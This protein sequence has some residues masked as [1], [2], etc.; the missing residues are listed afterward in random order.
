[1]G[2]RNLTGAG[3]GQ[4]GGKAGNVELGVLLSRRQISRAVEIFDG[5]WESHCAQE[6]TRTAL[7]PFLKI[8]RASEERRGG[9]QRIGRPMRLPASRVVA[10]RRLRSDA[11]LWVKAMYHRDPSLGE[12]WMTRTWI[13]DRHLPRADG[14]ISRRPG[15]KLGDRIVL[16]VVDPGRCPAIYVVTGLPEDRRDLVRAVF[17]AEVDLYG[18]VT[19][20][21]VL[22]AVP[23]DRAPGLDV[24]GKS[25]QGLQNGYVRLDDRDAY[26]RLERRLLR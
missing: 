23:L 25:P 18:W 4:P 26:R 19:P 8:E 21:D 24:L 22:A 13:H 7:A 14:G 9:G 20:V 15:Y 10:R 5:W 2:S 12:W 11:G 17:P 1:M 6:V 16:Y 3:L